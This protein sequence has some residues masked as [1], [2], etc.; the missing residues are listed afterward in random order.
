MNTYEYLIN[1]IVPTVNEIVA[2][3][4]EVDYDDFAAYSKAVE[5]YRRQLRR[6]ACISACALGL[7]EDAFYDDIDAYIN[8]AF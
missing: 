6:N 7:V 4:G 2:P 8:V 3:P 5:V 1:N